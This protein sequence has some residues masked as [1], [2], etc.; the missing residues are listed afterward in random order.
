MRSA[1]LVLFFL[2]FGAAQA[3]DMQTLGTA[4]AERKAAVEA[5]GDAAQEEAHRKAAEARSGTEFATMASTATA[6]AISPAASETA[7]T[8]GASEITDA[9][10]AQAVGD[11]ARNDA[12][13][14]S[15]AP[16]QLAVVGP[17]SAA[18][19]ANAYNIN[20]M[21]IKRAYLAGVCVRLLETG[22]A[23]DTV[24]PVLTALAEKL[25]IAYPAMAGA[26]T[27]TA[28]ARD[29]APATETPPGT[30]GQDEAAERAAKE[31]ADRE[32]ADRAAKE[33]AERE[34][35]DR[36]AKEAA[37]RE[38]ADRAAKEAA[39]REA[40]DRAAKEAAEREAAEQAAKEAAERA[41][42]EKTAA[43]EPP[44]SATPAAEPVAAE[45]AA[46]ESAPMAA[47]PEPVAPPAAPAAP[48]EAPA[49]PA[50]GSV[51]S[52]VGGAEPSSTRAATPGAD[53]MLGEAECRALG[54]LG[55][56]PDL[57]AV[58]ARVL[59]KPLEYNHPKEMLLGKPTEISLV[60]RTDWEGKDLP[61]EVSE[62]LKGLPG[63]VRQGIT[64]I[65]RVMS[66]ELSGRN[67]EVSPGGR[68]ERTV[69]PPQP[70]SWNWQVSPNETGPAQPLKLRLYAHLQGPDGT[71]PPLLVKTLDATINVDVTT[72]DWIVNQARTLEPIYAVGA[73]LI[74]L[75]TA[76][77]T[78]LLSRRRREAYEGAG[79]DMYRA[80]DQPT[81]R[82]GPV[83]GDLNQSAADSR[84]TT[85][86]APA[87]PPPAEDQK[88][89]PAGTIP[90]DPEGGIEP[91]KD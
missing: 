77:M 34:A 35:A 82:N 60:L 7:A 66:A 89:K 20:A 72:W 32:V 9:T 14:H 31:A 4:E 88:E 83:I 65:T 52:I 28:D 15:A 43:A 84:V 30:A 2:L 45:P 10:V 8:C 19:L 3:A 70:V 6:A 67:F 69:S 24:Q 5:E 87:A 42:A 18:A 49:A 80:D 12:D 73:A 71:M 27:Q 37:E 63:E 79:A 58:L 22:S 56:C 85:P 47:A 51:P 16:A 29:A 61:T 44:A 46:P 38:A 21:A 11:R 48:A 26:E 62:E 53:G 75:L 57:N 13:A 90:V 76:L 54:V 59:E 78:F 40:A 55:N 64:K 33:A 39:E 41:A 91:K 36:A 68:Q 86:P 1:F 23:R 50:A 25:G 81:T 74:G 17:E